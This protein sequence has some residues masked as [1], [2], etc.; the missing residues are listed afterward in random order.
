MIGGAIKFNKLKPE[1]NNVSFVGN[2]AA[3]GNDIGAF[4]TKVAIEGGENMRLLDVVP[5]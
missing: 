5:G 2:K 3:Y 4:A 1:L